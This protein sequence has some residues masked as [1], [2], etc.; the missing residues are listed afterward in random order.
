MIKKKNPLKTV[1]AFQIHCLLWSVFLMCFAYEGKA[2]PRITKKINKE[3]EKI[4]QDCFIYIRDKDKAQEPIVPYSSDKIKSSYLSHYFAPWTIAKLVENPP[5]WVGN[6]PK[7]KIVE[8][9]YQI[10]LEDSIQYIQN[11]E[12]KFETTILRQVKKYLLKPGWG[13]NRRPHG[14]AWIQAVRNNIDFDRFPNCRKPGIL[15]RN[16]PLRTL[17]IHIRSFKDWA[18][19]GEGFPFDYLQV[20]SLSAFEPCYILHTTANGAWHLVITRHHTIGWVATLDVAFVDD[21]F[22]QK[23]SHASGYITSCQDDIPIISRSTGR[24]MASSRVGQLL[25][26]H[27]ETELGY[28]VLTAVPKGDGYA[29]VVLCIVNK[30]KMTELPILAT[31]HNIARIANGFLGK[32][33]GWGGIDGT[34]E[35]SMTL[36]DLFAPFGIFL[37]RTSTQQSK[38]GTVISLEGLKEKEKMKIIDGQCIPFA[39]LFWIPG[40]IM[41]SVGKNNGVS[42]M[43]HTIWGLRTKLPFIDWGR[44][45]IGKTVITPLTFGKEYF[46]IPKSLLSKIERM[47]LL[48]QNLQNP[49]FFID[50]LLKNIEGKLEILEDEDLQEDPKVFAL[51][52][53]YKDYIK[54]VKRDE[55]TGKITFYMQNE[56][57]IPWHGD[58]DKT[59]KEKIENPDLHDVL[60]QPYR[61]NIPHGSIPKLNEDPGRFRHQE[62][63]KA[64]YGSTEE[65]VENDLQQVRWM[66]KTLLKPKY[67]SFNMNNGAAAALKRV[68][69]ELDE[70]PEHLKKYVT[71]TTGTFNWRVIAGTERLSPHSYGIAIDINTKYSNYWRW[72]NKEHF[73]TKGLTYINRI[74]EEI[75]KIFERNHFIWGGRWYHY[76]TM[77]FEYRPEF[78]QSKLK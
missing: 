45:I 29:E 47:T 18:L 41:L 24:Y 66:P 15:I 63:M 74:P 72:D 65:E 73:D 30:N 67:V 36:R 40:H 31:P 13:G 55:E 76:D 16:T 34:R 59:H 37:P 10:T 70:L 62:F 48:T 33:Y 28:E 51:A 11:Q 21:D 68:S 56:D 77:H 19:S 17:P 12:T 46:G 26:L 9:S 43:L 5:K 54:N 14:K 20:D 75:V 38:R 57:V 64:I 60:F 3:L 4:P 49:P 69:H 61:L 6:I 35:C 2:Y 39:T 50:N 8:N 32:Q 78:F 22:I 27:A 42:Y 7:E 53:A 23:W 71:S 52:S 44:A 1:T 58:I 25:P